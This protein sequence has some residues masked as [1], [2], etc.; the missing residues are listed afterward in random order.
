M[1]NFDGDQMAQEF[2]RAFGFP[3]KDASVE[4]ILFLA[5]FSKHVRGRCRSNTALRN[6]LI[7]NFPGSTFTEVDHTNRRG[8]SYKALRIQSKVTDLSVMEADDNGE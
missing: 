4:Q 1:M 8:E 3:I 5:K 6:Y 2:Q 7:R